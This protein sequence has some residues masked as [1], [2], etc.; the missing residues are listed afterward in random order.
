MN[1]GPIRFDEFAYEPT[2]HMGGQKFVFY[3]TV[4]GGERITQ[5]ALGKLSKGDNIEAHQHSSMIERFLILKG[6]C[7]FCIGSKSYELFEREMIWVDVNCVHS[8]HATVDIEFLYWGE[9]K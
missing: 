2:S 7:I 9:A 8:I 1:N 6:E 3:P 5:I 4:S